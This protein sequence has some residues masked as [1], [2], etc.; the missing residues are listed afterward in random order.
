M[1][2]AEYWIKRLKLIRHPEG[3]YFRETYRSPETVKA[4]ALPERFP[5]PRSISTAIYFLLKG[6]EVSCLHRIK[7]DEIWHYY[8]GSSLT[9]HIIKEGGCSQERLGPEWHEGRAFQVIVPAGAWFGATVDE[10]D[11]YT[12]VGCTVAP[13]FDFRDFE[14]AERADLLELYPQYRD[15]IEKLARSE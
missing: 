7:S 10:P 6:N 15:I 14:L 13:G 2:D 11:S 3:G 4:E 5:H 8:T 12:L 1:H 9:I